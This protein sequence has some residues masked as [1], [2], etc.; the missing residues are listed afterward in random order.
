MDSKGQKPN[1]LVMGSPTYGDVNYY[2]RWESVGRVFNDECNFADI[3]VC[4]H[5]NLITQV[6]V[7]SHPELKIIATA[8]TG[9]THL[10][11][12]NPK[13]KIVSLK[14][15]TEF[16]TDVRSVAEHTF[17]L[18]HKLMKEI[19]PLR[20]INGK[21]LGV[22]GLGRIG[23]HVS[24]LGLAYKMR[25]FGVDKDI[26]SLNVIVKNADILT[27]HIPEEEGT[28][29]LINKKLINSMKQGSVVVNTS[30]GSV[31]DELALANALNASELR[32]AA[33]DTVEDSGI[34]NTRV[35]NLIITPHLAGST[36]EDRIKTDEFICEKTRLAWI[37]RGQ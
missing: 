9:H 1:I 20:T 6:I 25:V 16:L 33:V 35:R 17:Y 12:N 37:Q 13:I 18:I 36:L 10:K 14:G 30:R 8:N 2:D 11:F 28:Y 32:G 29:K 31:I 24:R 15:E 7:D 3:I 19:M 23:K 27:L 22:I 26:G 4:D 34:L 5:R 21:T